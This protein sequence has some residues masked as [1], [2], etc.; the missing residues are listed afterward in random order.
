LASVA[1]HAPVGALVGHVA[2][3][4]LALVG[5]AFSTVL[6]VYSVRTGRRR[7]FW[8]SFAYLSAIDALAAWGIAVF[9][10]AVL[11]SRPE[12]WAVFAV[13]TAI[14]AWGLVLLRRHFPPEGRYETLLL[15]PTAT[16]PITPTSIAPS[17]PR[18]APT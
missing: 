4:A 14:G 2:E 13:V 7:W 18:G 11:A 5:H 6:I 12:F 1:A 8:L 17:H 3:R 9:G 15:N 16:R 10:K